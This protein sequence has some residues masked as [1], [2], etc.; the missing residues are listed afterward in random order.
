[1]RQKK[2]SQSKEDNEKIRRVKNK[3]RQLGRQSSSLKKNKTKVKYGNE[4]HVKMENEGSDFMTS[5]LE[6]V[7]ESKSEFEETDYEKR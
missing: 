5:S 3:N 6:S 2:S 7:E 1:M 4:R